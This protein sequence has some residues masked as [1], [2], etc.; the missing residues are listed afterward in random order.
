[1]ADYP[2]DETRPL[3]APPRRPRSGGRKGSSK[4]WMIAFLTLLLL[5]AAGVLIWLFAFRGNGGVELSSAAVDFGD[6]DLGKK[7]AVQTVTL[8]NGGSDPLPIAAV[9][10]EGENA[11]DFQVTDQSTCAAGKPLGK[12]KSCTIGVRFKPTARDDRSAVLVVRFGGGTAPLSVDLHGAGTG[13]A[14]VVLETT[15]LDLGSVGLGKGT[16]TRTM[17]VTNAGN[18]P[19]EIRALAIEGDEAGDFKIAKKTS[20]RAKKKLK[21][22]ATCAIAVSFKP[23][24][25]GKRTASLVIVHDAEG[26]PAE[27]ALVGEATGKSQLAFDPPAVDFGTLDVGSHSKPQTVALRNTGTATLTVAEIAIGGDNAGEFELAKGGTCGAGKRVEPGGSCT[28]EVAFAPAD[29]G[30]RSGTLEVTNGA[31][32]VSELE[33]AGAGATQETATATAETVT[34]EG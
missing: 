28:V 5:V 23:K 1:M 7:S 4:G 18:A 16:R 11:K 12:D 30:D 19:L 26:S 21:A 33:L 32:K 31:G 25:L 9:G 24:E 27:V 14:A 6:Q 20:C 13:Q 15:R 3:D 17:T 22:G 34:T 29:A 8:S 10:I 2:P